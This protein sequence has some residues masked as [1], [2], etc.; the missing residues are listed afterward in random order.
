MV[1][2]TVDIGRCPVINFLFIPRFGI[3]GACWACVISYVVGGVARLCFANK[4]NNFYFVRQIIV[5]S[6]LTTAMVCVISYLGNYYIGVA[7]SIIIVLYTWYIVK[8]TNMW[9]LLT[10]KR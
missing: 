6:I 7:I 4:F 5:L 8:K 2:T 3:F 9:S 1:A 10:K